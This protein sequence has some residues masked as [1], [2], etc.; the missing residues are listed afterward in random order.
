M[1][2]GQVEK[3]R[4]LV[5]EEDLVEVE[6]ALS[7]E[8]SLEPEEI[9]LDILFEDEH[10]LVIN[11]PAGLVVHPATG[12][13]KGTFVNALLFHCQNLPCEGLRPGI[14]HRL[15]KDTSGLLI[16]AKTAEAQRALVALFASREVYKEYEA[17][18]VGHPAGQMID[19]PL[20]RSPQNRKKMA[21][22][23][24]GK[25]AL[26]E[27]RPL[28]LFKEAAHINIV[29]HTGRTHQIRVH[30]RFIGHPVLGDAL[31]GY[32]GAN[33]RWGAGRQ[34]LHAKTLKFTHPVTGEKLCFEA[35]LPED[36]RLLLKKL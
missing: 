5:Q 24:T 27:L 8:L 6:F 4:Y 7:P 17:I 31:Y 21:V 15:D 18:V 1:V 36:M 30:M 16:A 34:M 9:P 12:H 22:V 19:Q 32:E 33:R 3:K 10:L 35:S 14:V 13:W 20:G 25:K 28:A 26:T 2:N 23:G 11:K 29:L